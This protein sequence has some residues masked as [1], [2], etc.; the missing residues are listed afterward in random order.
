MV[1]RGY[2][3]EE[4]KN[5]P[6]FAD[7]YPAN[8]TDVQV[9]A[10]QLF[11]QV[12]KIMLFHTEY[13]LAVTRNQWLILLSKIWLF[14]FLVKHKTLFFKYLRFTHRCSFFLNFCDC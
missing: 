3:F 10:Y 5:D 8:E 11:F 4:A 2:S 9:Q 12:N 1:D 14:L 7:L 6:R 13:S